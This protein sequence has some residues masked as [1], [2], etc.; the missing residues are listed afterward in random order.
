M[1][2][3][4]AWLDSVL[5]LLGAGDWTTVLL[6]GIST[7]SGR[8]VLGLDPSGWVGYMEHGK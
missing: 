7:P 2:K 8:G 4:Q 3:S 1:T 6:K 5:T